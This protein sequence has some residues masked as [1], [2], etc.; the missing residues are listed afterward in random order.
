MFRR[1]PYTEYSQFLNQR[2]QVLTDEQ[3]KDQEL[4]HK[5][6][7]FGWIIDEGKKIA[8]SEEWKEQKVK[9][10][11]IEG[12]RPTMDNTYP[13]KIRVCFER[14]ILCANEI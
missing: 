14:L 11:I 6:T 3:L 12:L 7:K 13:E 4:L 10:A 8:V 9:T 2:T 5:L 1:L